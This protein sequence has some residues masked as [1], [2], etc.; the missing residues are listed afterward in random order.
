MYADRFR[1]EGRNKWK[2][3]CI[4][5]GEHDHSIVYSLKPDNFKLSSN[6][7]TKNKDA[8]LITN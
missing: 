5:E 3:E 7:N 8:C 2:W 1:H 6:I 4:R